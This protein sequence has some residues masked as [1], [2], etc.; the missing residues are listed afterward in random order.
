MGIYKPGDTIKGAVAYKNTGG[1]E[2]SPEFRLVF[3]REQFGRDERLAVGAWRGETVKSNGVGNINL[4]VKVPNVKPGKYEGQLDM[5]FNGK[6]TKGLKKSSSDIYIIKEEKPG[7]EKY[8][9]ESGKQ[10][11]TELGPVLFSRIG[12][13]K[14]WLKNCKGVTI[15]GGYQDAIWRN[16]DGV[17]NWADRSQKNYDKCSGFWKHYELHKATALAAKKVMATGKCK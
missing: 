10:W 15:G 3:Y 11:Q 16:P 14:A 4:P 1:A 6:V 12:Q 9:V 7:C 2:V 8:A 17:Y 5:K 13:G